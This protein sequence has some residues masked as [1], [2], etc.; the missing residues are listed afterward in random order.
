M[1]GSGVAES[2]HLAGADGRI[3]VG[4]PVGRIARDALVDEDEGSLGHV[5]DTVAHARWLIVL[6]DCHTAISHSVDYWRM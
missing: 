2:A 6:R 5:G 3:L 1:F 4:L